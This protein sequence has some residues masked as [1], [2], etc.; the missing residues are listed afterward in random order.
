MSM[1]ILNDISSVYLEQVVLD[2]AL[3]SREE[4]M[5]RMVTPAQ[6]KQQERAR[7][8]RAV[9]DDI[10]ATEQALKKP[11]SAASTTPTFDTPA[12]EVRKLKP[13]QKKRYSCA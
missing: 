4:R 9:L 5:A 12:A 11:K 1:N 2:E 6:R 7:K 13:G 10:Q 3:R 8:G